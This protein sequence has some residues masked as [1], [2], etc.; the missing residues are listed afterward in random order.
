MVSSEFGLVGTFNY[1]VSRP[2]TKTRT[3]HLNIVEKKNFM[4]II[5]L[6]FIIGFSMNVP[7]P[8]F[9]FIKQVL[10]SLVVQSTNI[11]QG[12]RQKSYFYYE[13][14]IVHIHVMQVFSPRVSCPLDFYLRWTTILVHSN[15]WKVMEQRQTTQ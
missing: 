1:R 4:Q 11:T 8:I 3:V 5:D 9:I 6:K 13:K 2:H 14:D 10:N 12:S 7:K 15:S